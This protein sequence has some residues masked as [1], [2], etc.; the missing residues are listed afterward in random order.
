MTGQPIISLNGLEVFI[1][2][3]CHDCGKKFS[4]V[5]YI[6]SWKYFDKELL[7]P[8]LKKTKNCALCKYYKFEINEHYCEM[9]KFPFI[10]EIDPKIFVCEDF[11][12]LTAPNF[13]T[14]V[15]NGCIECKHF[16]KLSSFCEKYNLGINSPYLFRCD[17]YEEKD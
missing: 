2:C 8:H 14:I 1:N 11:E 15:F 17:D 10:D 16:N 5:G 12:Y 6:K 9:H 4:Q 13:K 7:P 3:Q